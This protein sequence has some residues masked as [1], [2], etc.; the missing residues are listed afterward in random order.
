[1]PPRTL[2]GIADPV[3]LIDV[4]PKGDVGRQHQRDPVCGMRLEPAD[5]AT[6]TRWQGTSYSF[7]SQE[8]AEI[9]ADAPERYA[10]NESRT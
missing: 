1:M 8:C 10:D 6:V 9:F 7:C 5:V 4:R 2:K 3:N